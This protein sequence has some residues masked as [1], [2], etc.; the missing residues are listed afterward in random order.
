MNDGNMKYCIQKVLTKVFSK[1]YVLEFALFCVFVVQSIYNLML[2]SGQMGFTISNCIMYL[3]GQNTH[4]YLIIAPI[5]IISLNGLTNFDAYSNYELVR[6]RN[7]KHYA[8]ARVGEVFLFCAVTVVIFSLA[9]VCLYFPFCSSTQSWMI[10]NDFWITSLDVT[11]IGKPEI[12]INILLT[13]ICITIL[14]TLES[15]RDVISEGDM[16][17]NES[18]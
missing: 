3:L 6:F 11:Q 2:S 4:Y 10:C 15:K 9:A 1:I 18:G 12:W 16:E 14:T 5:A 17:K 13:L 7:R 8:W